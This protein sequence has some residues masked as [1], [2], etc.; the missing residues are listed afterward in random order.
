VTELGHLHYPVYVPSRGRA[1]RCLT[2]NLLSKFKVPHFVVVEP[3]EE[4]HYRAWLD[5]DWTELLVLPESDAGITFA[6]NWIKDHAM[7]GKATRHWQVDD[8][9]QGL[10]TL[11][12]RKRKRA[13]PLSVMAH[14]EDF[15]DRYDNIGIAGT[16]AINFGADYQD[17]FKLNQQ[18]YCHVLVRS[19]DLR[20]RGQHGSEDTDYSL[21]V[22]AA[23]DCTV[24]FT[25]WQH[26]KVASGKMA[27]GNT[28][29]Y[30]DDGRI[31]RARELQAAWPTLGIKVSRRWD[32][33]AMNLNHIWRKFPQRL[34][35][36]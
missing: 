22:L 8:N 24:M 11:T 12:N 14:M 15:V 31:L 19:D 33:P 7:R 16:T 26:S 32:R 34:E 9:L 3:Q 21:Q 6:R 17:P 28:E 23:G 1:S 10:F 4:D 18:V 20:W 35:R 5:P 13:D 2:S 27:G 29:G 36:T 30:E 25:I